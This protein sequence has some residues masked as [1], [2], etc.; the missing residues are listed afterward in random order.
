MSHGVLPKQIAEG[1]R[2]GMAPL[3]RW[4]HGIGVTANVVTVL[5]FAITAAGSALLALDRPL[6][7]FVVLL[8]GTLSDTLDGAL[9]RAAGGGTRFGAFLDSTFDRLSDAAMLAAVIALAADAGD[10]LLLWSALA[11]LV[12]GFLV[13]YTRAKAESLGVAANVGFAPREARLTIFLVGLGI[14]AILGLPRVFAAAVVVIALLS[15]VTLLQRI[16]AV[17]TALRTEKER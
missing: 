7:A 11:A 4:L 1:T 13:P 6:A 9:A 10:G 16:A 17:A 5:G 8:V 14:W 2:V 3:A 12:G 15:I